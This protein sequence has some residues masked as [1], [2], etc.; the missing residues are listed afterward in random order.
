MPG[1]RGLWT[2]PDGSALRGRLLAGEPSDPWIVASPLARDQLSRLL[3][4]EHRVAR[5][6][7]VWCWDDVWQAVRDGSTRGPTRLSAAAVRTLLR[8]AVAVARRDGALGEVSDAVDWPGF[9]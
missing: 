5:G 9:R 1:A 6:T 2:G 8:E 3:A 4:L 7:R